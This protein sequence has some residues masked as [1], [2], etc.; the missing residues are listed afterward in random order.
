MKFWLVRITST[1]PFSG[2]NL[3]WDLVTA[4]VGRDLIR[5]LTPF[6]LTSCR[7][8]CPGWAWTLMALC[9]SSAVS[10]TQTL[11]CYPASCST[12]ICFLF[13]LCCSLSPFAVTP[14]SPL[15]PLNLSSCSWKELV[16]EAATKCSC[17][18]LC[19]SKSELTLSVFTLFESA[20][21]FSMFFMFSP[22]Q[23]C[24]SSLFSL[25]IIFTCGSFTSFSSAFTM[26]LW[27]LS[28]RLN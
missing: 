20:S 18:N 21:R 25:V 1:Q 13:L 26:M 3:R 12:V 23:H 9:L 22:F 6:A 7:M 5:R 24:F 15:S 11:K 16:A 14:C 2:L 17:S 28:Y 27:L 19:C 10:L 4:L 8:L